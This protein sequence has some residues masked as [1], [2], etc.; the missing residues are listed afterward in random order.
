MKVA[1]ITDFLS[2]SHFG[3][4]PLGLLYLVSVLKQRGVDVEL[5]DISEAKRRPSALK[6]SGP[7]LV[8]YSIKTGYHRK[9]LDLNR[10]LKKEFGFISLFGGPH[11]TFCP[12]IIKEEGV[13]IVCRG[14]AERAIV[15]LIDGIESDNYIHTDNC[16]VK[17]D[18]VIHK[19]SLGRLIEDL[20]SIP[21]P[22]RRILDKY[23]LFK[24]FRMRNFL[25]SRGCPY[26]CAY[27]HNHSLSK[28]YAGKGSYVR[29]RSVGNL[30]EEI[31]IELNKSRLNFINFEDD[32]FA[33]DKKWLKDF[34]DIYPKAIN[35]PF[36]CHI[37]ADIFDEEVAY[38]LKKAGCFSVSSG[39][40]TAD[41]SVR[42]KIL[43]RKISNQSILNMCSLL[44][45]QGINIALQNMLGV[46][47]TGL[48]ADLD[49][50]KLN[51]KCRADYSIT[52]MLTPYPGTKLAQTHSFNDWDKVGD[53]YNSSVYPLKNKR[54]RENLQKLFAL[55]VKMPLLSKFVRLPLGAVY[56]FFGQVWKYLWG[57]RKIFPTGFNLKYSLVYIG[58][59]FLGSR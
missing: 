18:G 40:E 14:E 31:L 50:L 32:I 55:A 16:W 10:Q 20:D 52:S 58:R 23:L 28:L 11:A 8:G 44:K 6:Q 21:F 13:D 48:K 56:S 53:Y 57:R 38:L 59:Y 41:E 19:N 1:F 15:K 7:D 42:E 22:E 36:H 49:T 3:R 27:C 4:E 35:L 26:G 37:K 45:A 46:P 47:G 9:F 39:I 33:R 43:C 25:S 2:K 5:L 29:Q 12:D 30:I 24:N 54:E 51:I 34:S 17:K